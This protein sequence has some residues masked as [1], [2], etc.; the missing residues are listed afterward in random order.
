M[1]IAGKKAGA[2]TASAPRR[3]SILGATGSVGR[4]TLDLI[5]RQ[6]G[7]YKVVALTAQ[8]NVE[9][10]AAQARQFNAELAVIG[11]ETHLGALKEA[12]AGSGVEAAAGKQALCEA[13]Q[14]PSDWIMA[15]IVGA[16]GLGPTLAAIRQGA[17]VALANKECLVCAGE[18]V[19]EEVKRSGAKLLPVD[20]EHNAIYQV[21][22]FERSRTVDRI[23]LT[24]SGG[25]FLNMD[26]TAM[27][28]V[29]PAQALAHPNWDMGDKISI[30]SA[31]MMNKGLESIEAYH[32]FPVAAD[33][34]DI[35]IHPQS[36]VHSL[37]AYVDGSVLAQLGA[38]DMRTPIAY[39]LAWPDRM[40]TPTERLDLSRIGSLDF[41]A[42]DPMRF[43]ALRLTRE[44]LQAG[45]T[46]PTILNAANEIA[47]AAFL[48]ERLGFLEIARIV[49]ETLDK[50]AV[51]SVTDLADVAAADDEARA[52][53]RELAGLPPRLDGRLSLVQG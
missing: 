46:A 22:D 32:L 43:P 8:R 39:T 4:N 23:I 44:A 21:F 40:A 33:Q 38:P 3:V 26:V 16:A 6:A 24:A 47:V 15:G 50:L 10:L 2:G 13:A 19:L 27:A 45:G 28:Q 14:R 31:T 34:I 17:I 1:A 25:P 53:A 36:V 42:P 7:A 37:V 5:S 49:E 51:N 52:V 20:S 48:S 9:L 35:L 12:L 41:E 29:T 18:L 11:D 30:D